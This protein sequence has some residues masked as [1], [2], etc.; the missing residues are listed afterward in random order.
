MTRKKNKI[1]KEKVQGIIIQKKV[2]NYKFISSLPL[3]L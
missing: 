2:F 3:K 1:A